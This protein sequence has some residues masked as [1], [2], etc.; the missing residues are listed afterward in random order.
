MKAA[1][2]GW[3]KAGMKRRNRHDRKESKVMNR[4]GRQERESP[5]A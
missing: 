3:G 1:R 5:D 4:C 2:L